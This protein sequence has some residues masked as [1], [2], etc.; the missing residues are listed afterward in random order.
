M[1]IELIVQ[2]LAP[3]EELKDAGENYAI[4]CR[5][6]S[7]DF[8]PHVETSIALN[9]NV[10]SDS[11]QAGIYRNLLG[12]IDNSLFQ[13]K[14][15]KVVLHVD[16]KNKVDIKLHAYDMFES[17]LVRF[18]NLEQLLTEFYLFDRMI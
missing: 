15:E 16:H 3:D 13:L 11:P 4:Y 1:Q 14:I 9:P 6:F 18:K 7:M 10:T 12:D 5:R 17:S 8:V 2:V